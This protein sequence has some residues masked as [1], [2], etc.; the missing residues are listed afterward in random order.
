M[1]F[2]RYLGDVCAL[3]AEAWGA[4]MGIQLAWDLGYRSV[5]LQSDSQVLCSLLSGTDC[6]PLSIRMEIIHLRAFARRDWRFVCRHIYRECNVV[7]DGMSSLSL[8]SPGCEEYW[9]IPPAA[10]RLL[11]FHDVIGVSTPRIIS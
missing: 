6:A 1:G 8:D 11:L 4:L 3:K 2:T 5:A 10:V 7:A 9:A